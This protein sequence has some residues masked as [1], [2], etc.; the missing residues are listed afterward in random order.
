ME[1]KSALEKARATFID[2]QLTEQ[3]A[4]LEAK[5]WGKNLG[6]KDGKLTLEELK[7][8]IKQKGIELATLIRDDQISG[9]TITDAL[10]TKPTSPTTPHT[11]L[12][13]ASN[14]Q[15]RR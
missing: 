10:T 5:G 7:A 11:M 1:L 13:Q 12:S 4:S 6:D 9:K 14:P 2:N 15:M 3:L 8:S